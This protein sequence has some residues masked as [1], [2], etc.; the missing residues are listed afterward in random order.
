MPDP[1]LQAA[2]ALVCSL[3]A[4][5]SAGVPL[6]AVLEHQVRAVIA[7]HRAGSAA[8]AALRATYAIAAS[9]PELPLETARDL[10]AR[11]HRFASWEA[12]LERGDEQVLRA[13]EAALDALVEG[14]V[15]S[16]TS[17]LRAHPDLARARSTYAHRA[18][19]LHHVGFNGVEHARQGGA[20]SN[21]PEV[22]RVLLA[23]GA[24][25]DATCEIYSS[26]TT[27]TLAASSSWVAEA[28]VQVGIVEALLDA[29]AQ[30]EGPED[31]SSPLWTALVWGYAAAVDAMVKR[32]ARLGNVVL[33]AA[34]GDL[35]LTRRFV[36]ARAP[37]PAR[38]GARGPALDPARSLEYATI[39]AASLDRREVLAYLL[40]QGPDLGFKEP[41][42]GAT[43]RGAAGYS[44]PA[45]GRP[46]GNPAAVAMI[47][48]R[49]ASGS[50]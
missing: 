27:M 45:A 10:V 17:L 34:A 3:P 35:A 7:A 2:A 39:Y 16:L 30:I 11:E 24:E 32:G 33:A 37:G 26:D 43:A 9:E 15:P 38:I 40:A 8:L 22:A 36:E 44:H 49:R 18:T 42:Y 5:A 4:G 21:A 14:D 23:A 29:G 46:N 12:A 50:R 31:D 6:R 13:F 28:G 41:V 20:P 48:A 25:P 47:E 19:L 1:L